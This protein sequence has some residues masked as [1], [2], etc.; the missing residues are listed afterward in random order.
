MAVKKRSTALRQRDSSTVGEVK[1]I[2]V[3]SDG[4]GATAKR[5]LDAVLA[6]YAETEVD[7]ALKRIYSAETPEGALAEG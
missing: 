7:D 1:K 4:T 6:Q 3:V 5:L 2:A